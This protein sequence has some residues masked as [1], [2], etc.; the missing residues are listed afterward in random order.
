[1]K[2]FEWFWKKNAN[3]NGY[4]VIPSFNCCSTCGVSRWRLT[5]RR[6]KEARARCNVN[7]SLCDVLH[8][9]LFW[10]SFLRKKKKNNNNKIVWIDFGIG[11][12]PVCVKK[13]LDTYMP[14]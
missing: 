6:K 12:H 3:K 7:D 2:S 4:Y 5:T 10:I 8:K 9:K 14:P 13:L 11:P 1:M